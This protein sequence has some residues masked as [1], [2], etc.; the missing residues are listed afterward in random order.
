MWSSTHFFPIVY[1]QG[2]GFSLVMSFHHIFFFTAD[3]VQGCTVNRACPSSYLD[4]KVGCR[5]SELSWW[6]PRGVLPSVPDPDSQH[7]LDAHNSSVPQGPELWK[8]W[9]VHNRHGCLHSGARNKRT[10]HGF[11]FVVFSLNWEDLYCA[12]GDLEQHKHWSRMK[13]GAWKISRSCCST[14]K[15]YKK[16]IDQHYSYNPPQRVWIQ[17]FLLFLHK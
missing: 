3:L 11:C 9:N 2:S 14:Q 15:R 13:V 7:P 16:V 5:I 10:W 17:S 4:L 6:P 12:S 1:V 8:N